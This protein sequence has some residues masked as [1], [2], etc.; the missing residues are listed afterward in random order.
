MISV[1]SNFAVVLSWLC[2]GDNLQYVW[3]LWIEFHQ[4][5]QSNR[6]FMAIFLKAGSTKIALFWGSYLLRGL[7]ITSTLLNSNVNFSKSGDYNWMK[8]S[9]LC[10]NNMWL[11]SK[12]W[13]VKSVHLFWIYKKQILLLC[14]VL[15]T[16]VC[17]SF[18]TSL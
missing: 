12:S 5:E 1:N 7:K 6:N 8:L 11:Q 15:C 9:Q 2:L 13:T 3:G 14:N 16:K 4:M 18:S 17:H 10:S